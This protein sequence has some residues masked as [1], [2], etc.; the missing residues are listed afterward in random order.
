MNRQ[1]FPFIAL[2]VMCFLAAGNATGQEAIRL[3]TMATRE[4]DWGQ[5]FS[6]MN[7]ELIEESQ[8]QLRFQFYWGRS[9]EQLIE[10][11]E[12]GLDA[13]SLTGTGAGN[14]L[15]EA[16]I[17][18]LPML[19]S[20]YKQLDYVRDGLTQ[21]FE[22]KLA[23]KGYILLGWGDLGFIH[24]FSTEPI[25]TQGDLQQTLVWAWDIDLIGREF[26]EA[27]G[28]GPV[29][30][31]INDVLPA[32]ENDSIQTVYTSPLGCIAFGWH[33]KVKYM[34]TFPDFRL[35]AGIGA[36]IMS[37]DRYEGLSDNHKAL[38][39]RITLEYHKQLIQTIRKKNEESLGILVENGIEVIQV[40]PAE[41]AQ[42]K[43]VAQDVRNGFADVLFPQDL[44][45]TVDNLLQQFKAN[46]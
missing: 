2:M 16:F 45:D 4:S 40:T 39:R 30:L 29:L 7:A 34:S 27:S 5:I 19:F 41:Q 15:P 21:R 6:K 25:R 31:P 24:L 3:G 42:W 38:L 11:V 37:R 13:V 1:L 18:Q 22:E 8:D 35:A 20:E 33:T 14:I 23:D 17:F 43:E 26:I 9:E 10:S 32:L 28:I 44:L 46:Q 36:T 12:S